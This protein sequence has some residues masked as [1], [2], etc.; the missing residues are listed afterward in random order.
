MIFRRE[1]S[2]WQG[3]RDWL[4]SGNVVREQSSNRAIGKVGGGSGGECFQ[5][6]W[7][8]PVL[9]NTSHWRKCNGLFYDILR[10]YILIYNVRANAGVDV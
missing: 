10:N 1:V 6:G 8:D 4:M 9:M 3:K 2:S 5:C 7:G